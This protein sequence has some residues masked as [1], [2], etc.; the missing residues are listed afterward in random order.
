MCPVLAG[1]TTEI[2]PGRTLRKAAI[3]EI[4]S[5]KELIESI[6]GTH[7]SGNLWQTRRPESG[8][9]KYVTLPESQW[10]YF[11]IEFSGDN[12]ELALLEKALSIAPCGI[13]LGFTLSSTTFGTKKVPA[14]IY[15]PP[16]LFQSLSALQDAL[17]SADGPGQSLTNADVEQVSKIYAA[18]KAHDHNVVDLNRVFQLLFQLKDLPHF[19]PLQVLGFFAVLE[20]ILTH[21][22][23]PEDRHDSITRQI[24][25]KL[26]LLNR[27]WQPPLDYSNFAAPSHDILWSKMYEYRSAIAHGATPDFKSKLKILQNPLNA[28]AL[29]SEAAKKTICQALTEPQLLADLQN[30]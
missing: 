20:S 28:N 9:G 15:S 8:K 11:V 18:L 17:Y 30:C 12:Q 1:S 7:F 14:C 16:R 25:Q 19:S 3:E 6:F 24:K 27:R 29:V 26:A 5:I 10:R 13:E 21:R 4:K 2:I 23:N 22:P